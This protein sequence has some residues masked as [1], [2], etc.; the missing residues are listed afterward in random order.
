[1]LASA[2]TS[3][4]PV[5]GQIYYNSGD[6]SLYVCTVGGATPTWAVVGTE[7]VATDTTLGSVKVYT[8]TGATANDTTSTASRTYGVQL[9]GDNKAVV[10]VPW[11]NTNTVTSV[12]GTE[13]EAVSGTVLIQGTGLITTSQSGQNITIA[14]TA[15]NYVHTTNADLTGVVTSSG[16]ATAIADAALTIAKTNGLQTAL[17]GKVASNSTITGATK[18]IITFDSKGLVTSGRNLAAGDIPSLDAGKITSGTLDAAI[19]PGLD[20]SKITTGTIDAGLLPSYVDDVL[21]FADSAAFPLTGATG[22][23]YIAIDTNKTYRWSGSVY[24]YITSGA[25]DS[26]AGK[27]GVVTLDKG[28]VDLGNVDNT[29]DNVKNVF[30]ATKLTTPR[31]INGV[32]FD[33]DGPITVTAAAGTLTG[34][35]LNSTI[36]GSSLTS[37]GTLAN[38]TVT[39]AISGSVSGNAATATNVAYTGLTGEVPTWNQN[40][41]GSAGTATKATNIAGGLGGSIPYQTAVNTTALLANGTAGQVL[42]SAGGTAAPTWVTRTKSYN[43]IHASG[44]AVSGSVASNENRTWTITHG[45][46]AS[47]LY[48]VQVIQISGTG[49]GETVF[50][51]VTRTT[52]QV[53]VTFNTAP[54][55]GEYTVVIV[56]I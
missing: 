32:D 9:D 24:V 31:A 6:S 25:V 41:T 49:A 12:K 40:T 13:G 23:I 21:E 10:N 53:A 50:T 11:T 8:G 34:T 43:L 55:S 17:D 2:P 22:K 45:M 52:T 35:S 33:G 37:V 4:T 46:G 48:M 54:T 27:T 38:L 26:V 19:I 15:N 30:T 51:D 14:T 20:A 1:V 56:K 3:P 18:A 42:Q 29:A 36:T 5:E 16:N 44:T 39:A 47:L 7:G 28:D